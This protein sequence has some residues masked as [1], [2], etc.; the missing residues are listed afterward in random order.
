MRLLA[1][2]ASKLLTQNSAYD[3]RVS[4]CRTL[5][6]KSGC[7]GARLRVD[8]VRLHPGQSAAAHR[9][10]VGVMPVQFQQTVVALPFQSDDPIEVDDV[11]SVDTGEMHRI[12]A[13]LDIADGQRAE[14]FSRPIKDIR[15]MRVRMDGHDRVDREKTGEA[16]ML[17]RNMAC[18]IVCWQTVLDLGVDL[19]RVM[20]A[21]RHTDM[22]GG[23]Q[24]P[25]CRRH[26][27]PADIRH[28]A[29]IRRRRS[30]DRGPAQE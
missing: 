3:P 21:G 14:I 5:R 6:R 15:V 1:R 29:R 30:G 10:C 11:A 4:P 19:D 13:R 27:L 25:D 28:G 22:R 2:I 20:V 16:V 23:G 17:H 9:D 7:G 26:R 8:E 24:K 12:K 18:R